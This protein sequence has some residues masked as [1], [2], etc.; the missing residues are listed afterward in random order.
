LGCISI[1]EKQIALLLE[2]D[3]AN[4]FM[5]EK[6]LKKKKRWWYNR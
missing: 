4:H 2:E 3:Y 5:A 6:K 1:F